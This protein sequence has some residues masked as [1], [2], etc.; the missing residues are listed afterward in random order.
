MRYDQRTRTYVERRTAEGL[1]KK[2]IMRCLK[3]AIARE[4][5]QVLTAPPAVPAPTAEQPLLAA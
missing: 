3:R 2:D 5:Y 4:M 1:S